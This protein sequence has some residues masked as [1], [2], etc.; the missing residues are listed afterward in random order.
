MNIMRF[1]TKEAAVFF[2]DILGIS[3]LTQGEINLAGLEKIPLDDVYQVEI[4]CKN[5]ISSPNQIIATWTLKRFRE[6]LRNIHFKYDVRISQLSDCAF[7]W[8]ENKSDLLM[9]A[10]ELMW[11]L[12]FSGVLCRGGLSFGEVITPINDKESFGSFILG[13]A[14]T[15]AAK[16]EARGKGCRIFTDADTIS[17]F[18][19]DFPGKVKSPVVSTKIYQEIFVPITNPL[20]YSISDEFKWY[21]IYDLKA[22]TTNQKDIDHAK[23]A[24][25]MAGLV[26]TLM[27]SPHYAWNSLNKHGLI[28]LAGSIESISSAISLHTRNS[29]A[30]LTA[31]YTVE[32]LN[33]VNRSYEIVQRH[34]YQYNVNALTNDAHVKIKKL[35]EKE[36]TKSL[37]Q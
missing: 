3:A 16:H 25:Y 12:T 22:S 19:E 2:V 8:S 20:D 29:D 27:Y 21:I 18:H 24:M 13:E 11:E 30:K 15:Q 10:S 17:H 32:S 31:E 5:N 36:V 23:H 7:V 26:S 9:A 37:V 6:A 4:N 33:K 34:F 1:E 14:V 28:Q 35:W